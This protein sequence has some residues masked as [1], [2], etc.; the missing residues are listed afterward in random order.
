[1]SFPLTTETTISECSVRHRS[2]EGV[3]NLRWPAASGRKPAD[4]SQVGR[5]VR[6]SCW[7]IGTNSHRAKCTAESRNGC[8]LTRRCTGVPNKSDNRKVPPL[9]ARYGKGTHAHRSQVTSGTK[10]QVDGGSRL[11][12]PGARGAGGARHPRGGRGGGHECPVHSG[13]PVRRRCSAGRQ[14]RRTEQR[15]VAARPDLGL[16]P[17]RQHRRV[18]TRHDGP[19]RREHGRDGRRV[20]LRAVRPGP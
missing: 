4:N 5:G 10:T 16:L 17:V 14:P 6:V 2:A 20:V 9:S 8:V 12:G 13:R 11:G 3:N 7:A 15:P 18:G 1:M 19:H